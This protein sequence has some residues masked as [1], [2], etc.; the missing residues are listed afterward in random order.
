MPTNAGGIAFGIENWLAQSPA[1]VAALSVEQPPLTPPNLKVRAGREA[2]AFKLP[3]IRLTFPGARGQMQSDGLYLEDP[4][5]LVV[6]VYALGFDA[7]RSL[8]EQV[9]DWLLAA[10]DQVYVG[11][12]PTQGCSL[13][14]DGV[15]QY[16]MEPEPAPHGG[17]VWHADMRYKTVLGRRPPS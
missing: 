15:L 10:S 8:A 9:N 7:C 12:P 16:L 14:P 13:T 2:R 4:F 17:D 11:N 1:L 5:A 6:A 3:W